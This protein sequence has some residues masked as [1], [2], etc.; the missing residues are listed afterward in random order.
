MPIFEFTCKSCG[1]EFETL[2]RKGKTPACASCGSENL[3]RHFSLPN[4]KSETTRG[5][6]MRAAKKRDKAQGRENVHEQINYEK[7]H[8]DG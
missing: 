4:V 5:L 6:A 7:S 2:V 1:N 8:D 3:E